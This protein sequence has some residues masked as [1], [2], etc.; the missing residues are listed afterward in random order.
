MA[1]SPQAGPQGA[2]AGVK[3]L[4]LSNFL[5]APMS[6]MFLADFGADVIK[7][8]RPGSGDE[9]RNWGES[10][11]GVGLYFKVLNRGKRA[12]TLDLRTPFGQEAVKRL[13]AD[14]DIVVENYRSGTLEKWG[15]GYDALKSINPGLVMMRVTGFGQTG[16][17]RERPGFGT[18]AEA[19][20]GYAQIS[21]YPDQPPLLPGFG[22]ADST[23]GLMAA[24]LAM[25]ALQHK[26]RT[27]EGQ[28]VDLAIYETL[29][30]L[31]GPH[32]I[33]YDQL[34]L[35]QER[36]GSR[37]PFTAPRNTFQTR[38][39]KWLAIAGSAQSTF[40]RI[41][42]VLEVPGLID[43]PRFADNRQRLKHVRE[44][45]EALQQAVGRYDLDDLLA[46]SA[47]LQSTMAPVNNVAQILADPQVQARENIATVH[48]EELG[49]PLRMQNV[50]GKL[51]AS[52]GNIR[53]PGP[54]LGRHNREI[55]VERLGYT[56]AELKRAGIELA[57]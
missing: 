23:T 8:E 47:D 11:E 34:G 14:M 48:D 19:Y 25:V 49:G 45:D 57:D 35:V 33:N 51:S 55:L 3:V 38:D 37:L 12:I 5:A 46:R 21:G 24:F 56:E 2:L 18:L 26:Q 29:L 13:V 17:Y 6:A 9:V 16:P 32:V 50:V 36:S 10:K 39:G 30:T 54:A 22:L 52:P 7:V 1:V 40:V 15:L 41:C 20:A 4:D 31:I 43:D 27:G 44:L 53:A 28:Y 42:Q